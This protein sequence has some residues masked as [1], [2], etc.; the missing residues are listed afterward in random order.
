[1]LHKWG[2]MCKTGAAG[3]NCTT[4]N[5]DDPSPANSDTLSSFCT[6]YPKTADTL[7]AF[8]TVHNMSG[9]GIEFDRSWGA[10][11]DLTSMP[12]INTTFKNNIFANLNGVY[13]AALFIKN[14][15]NN[16]TELP[17]GSFDRNVAF[18]IQRP[19]TGTY[20]LTSNPALDA[21]TYTPSSTSPV[22]NT[23]VAITGVT[24][25]HYAKARLVGTAPDR[26]AVE[27]Q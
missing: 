7:I 5:I 6:Y 16:N 19:L 18:G 15:A 27:R 17:N 12:T 9:S 13:P 25:D 21:V 2:S 10:G 3:Q 22:L 20:L 8:N 14:R 24:L 26:G 4:C 1:M 23:G 11:S